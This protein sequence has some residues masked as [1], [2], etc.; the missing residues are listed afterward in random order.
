M[1]G[2]DVRQAQATVMAGEARLHWLEHICPL[3]EVQTDH[4]RDQDRQLLMKEEGTLG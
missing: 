4:R 3:Q 1:V 2:I